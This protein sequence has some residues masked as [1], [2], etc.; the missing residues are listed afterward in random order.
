[1]D[2]PPCLRN[3]TVR[4]FARKA[5]VGV[6]SNLSQRTLHP[7]AALLLCSQALTETLKEINSL[8]IRINRTC[9]DF[10]PVDVSFLWPQRQLRS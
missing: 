10:P 6:V 2:S 1:M 7:E 5:Y 4:K 9:R 8:Y 3:G